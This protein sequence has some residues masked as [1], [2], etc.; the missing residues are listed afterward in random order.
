MALKLQRLTT[1]Y[2]A[3]LIDRELVA[4]VLP[5]YLHAI[6][7]HAMTRQCY[8]DKPSYNQLRLQPFLTGKKWPKSALFKMCTLLFSFSLLKVH[9]SEK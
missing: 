9:F 5:L 3:R 7:V 1:F 6:R 4:C 8:L 2:S